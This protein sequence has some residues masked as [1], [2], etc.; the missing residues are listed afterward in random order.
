VF[1]TRFPTGEGAWQVSMDGGRSP[2]WSPVGDRIYYTR[3]LRDLQ[4]TPF[5]PGPHAAVSFGPPAE[6]FSSLPMES[7]A[8]GVDLEA[9][10]ERLLAVIGAT[11]LSLA[12][13]A[14]IENWRAGR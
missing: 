9:N 8:M 5:T 2:M 12:S 14:F 3:T 1:L 4:M 11:D 10:G 6:V 7:M 13:L